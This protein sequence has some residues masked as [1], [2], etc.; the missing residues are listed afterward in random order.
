MRRSS[1]RL[2]VEEALIRGATVELYSR[3]GVPGIHSVLAA[4]VSYQGHRFLAQNLIPGILNAAQ[5]PKILYGSEPVCLLS[6]LS[7]SLSRTYSRVAIVQGSEVTVDPE[8]HQMMQKAGEAL[9]LKEHKVYVS[10]RS[11]ETVSIASSSVCKGIRAIDGRFYL[12]DVHIPTARDANWI[13]DPHFQMAILRP[14]LISML[15]M[16]RTR[17]RVGGLSLPRLA[18]LAF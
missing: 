13:G 8:L 4:I 11:Q 18:S 6:S 10:D 17:A 1:C 2:H 7:L 14:E 3:A 9:C 15:H 5:P 12:L 16:V